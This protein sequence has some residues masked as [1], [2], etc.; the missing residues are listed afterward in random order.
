M[1]LQ[2]YNISDFL[3]HKY[4]LPGIAFVYIKPLLNEHDINDAISVMRH[5]VKRNVHTTFLIP[6]VYLA[7]FDRPMNEDISPFHNFI[8]QLNTIEKAQFL[9][10]DCHAQKTEVFHNIKN[11]NPIQYL[12]FILKKDCNPST[13]FISPDQ[14]ALRKVKKLSSIFQRPYISFLKRQN[15]KNITLTGKNMASLLQKKRCIIIDDIINTG[16]TLT[17]SVD[18]LVENNIK[19]FIIYVTHVIDEKALLLFLNHPQCLKIIITNSLN[20]TVTHPKLVC[21]RLCNS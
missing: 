19:D 21:L 14:G 18:Y 20:I 12:R 15:L 3:K 16:R 13:I 8:L 4:S 17:V 1:I 10:I 7:Q 2:Y 11:I 5:T 6:F 9:I